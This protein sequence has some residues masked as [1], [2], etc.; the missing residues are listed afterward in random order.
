MNLNIRQGNVGM[1][2][3][4]IK[5]EVQSIHKMEIKNNKFQILRTWKKL[6]H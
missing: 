3:I 1:I 5:I 2:L 6:F 4:P